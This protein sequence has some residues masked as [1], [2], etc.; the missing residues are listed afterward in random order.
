MSHDR[1]HEKIQ[2][3]LEQLAVRLGLRWVPCPASEDREHSSADC[4]DGVKVWKRSQ[5][6]GECHGAGVVLE[7]YHH[8][9]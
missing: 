6:C 9:V 8:D 4:E 7:T 2:G 1:D 5:A 3:M